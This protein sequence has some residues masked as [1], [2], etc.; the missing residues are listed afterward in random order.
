MPR[1]I[2]P[3]ST[4]WPPIGASF[5]ASRGRLA[6]CRSWSA[7]ALT[8]P[9]VSAA[10]AALRALGQ[11]A[12]SRRSASSWTLSRSELSAIAPSGSPRRLTG[13][14]TPGR[15]TRSRAAR[16]ARARPTVA[17]STTLPSTESRTGA[18]LAAARPRVRPATRSGPRRDLVGLAPRS[19]HARG[20]AARR[21][22]GRRATCGG[23]GAAPRRRRRTSGS[24]PASGRAAFS[25]AAHAPGGSRRWRTPG[26][27]RRQRAE[28]RAPHRREAVAPV[29]SSSVKRIAMRARARDAAHAP[30]EDGLVGAREHVDDACTQAAGPAAGR[31]P[32]RPP[33]SALSAAERG[34]QSDESRTTHASVKTG[35]S[36]RSCGRR[37]AAARRAA[38]RRKRSTR[39]PVST[40]FCLPV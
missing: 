8:S 26:L 20:W 5:V 7:D 18:P 29:R 19:A 24:P 30:V 11:R 36:A 9:I 14:G 31:A 25:Q 35:A 37:L 2:T 3:S 34:G 21:T 32:G 12:E 17:V 10:C 27:E 1:I 6:R 40:S 16:R 13:A 22:A 23:P 15:G 4:A 28:A 39:P 33:G 38:R